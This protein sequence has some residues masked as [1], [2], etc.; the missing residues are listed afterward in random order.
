[1]ARI[2][3]IEDDSSMN[4][5]LVETLKDDD[6]EVYSAREGQAAIVIGRN[7]HFDLAISD[8]R[9][10]GMDGVEAL[11]Q[12]KK[13]QPDLKTV[14]ITGY[15]AADVPIRAIQRQVDD[16]LFKPFSLSY[17]LNTVNRVL[18]QEVEK[19]KKFTLASKL[20]S[21]FGKARN[22][23]LKDLVNERQEVFRGLY[24]GSRSGHLSKYA[25]REVYAKLEG[26][27]HWFREVLNTQDAEVAEVRGLRDEY[28]A[29]SNRIAELEFGN[30]TTAEPDEISQDEF[31][32][33]YE[34]IRSAH[35]GLDELQYAPLMRETP[36]E[37]FETHGKLLELKNQL[38]P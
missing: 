32:A 28:A 38:W 30:E 2:L 7:H 10:P 33:L 26:L 20:F 37:R 5:I 24:L 11:T 21:F 14:I 34:A 16:Y 29:L 31:D 27:E 25:A 35:I 13:N 15:A 18:E 3:V 6:H 9:L 1:M 4:Q 12:L 19:E 8:V 17:F 23:A 22:T 36:D